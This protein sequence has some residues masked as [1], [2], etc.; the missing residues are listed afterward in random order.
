MVAC[1]LTT[2]P[3]SLAIPPVGT[4]A[5]SQRTYVHGSHHTYHPASPFTHVAR[6]IGANRPRS[7]CPSCPRPRGP[8]RPR[9]GPR[10]RGTRGTRRSRTRRA[11]RRRA[12]RY[13]LLLHTSRTDTSHDFSQ[14]HQAWA[15]G[16]AIPGTRAMRTHT[17]TLATAPRATE[18]TAEGARP[19][20][21]ATHFTARK[22]CPTKL[23]HRAEC[24]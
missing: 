4:D 17:C 20:T 18:A 24:F 8:P 3:R 12:R 21:C 22:C 15:P 7:W 13:G 9:P 23:L 10:R 2:R 11:R 19:D 5:C 16:P 1:V 6:P 14:S